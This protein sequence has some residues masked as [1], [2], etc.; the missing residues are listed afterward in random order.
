MVEGKKDDESGDPKN[1]FL[2]LRRSQSEQEVSFLVHWLL[3][4]MI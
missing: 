3:T 4:L 2:M 1:H